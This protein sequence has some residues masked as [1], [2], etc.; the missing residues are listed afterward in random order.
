[1]RPEEPDGILMFQLQMGLAQRE[2][3]VL[4]Q[5]TRDGTEAKLRAGGWPNRAP[6]GYINV[7]KQIKS[8]KYE[9]WV[10]KDPEYNHV[11]RAAWDLLLTDRYTLD[12]ICEELTRQGF[13]RKS[14]KPWA[15]TDS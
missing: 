9:R 7:E 11:I 1:M 12:E 3:D 14:G 2:V 5:R 4:R 13:I 10:E 6:A 15:W 8:G